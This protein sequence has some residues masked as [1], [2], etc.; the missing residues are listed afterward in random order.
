MSQKRFLAGDGLLPR[1]VAFDEDIERPIAEN[2]KHASRFE[3]GV[4]YA[5]DDLC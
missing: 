4:G 3:R 5:R 2:Q 1:V